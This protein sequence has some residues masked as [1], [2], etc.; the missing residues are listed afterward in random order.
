MVQHIACD[1]HLQPPS[2]G[3]PDSSRKGKISILIE[4]ETEEC[5]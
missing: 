5:Q 1:L 3:G 4:T 2:L